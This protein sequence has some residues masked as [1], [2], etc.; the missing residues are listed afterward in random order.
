MSRQMSKNRYLWGIA[1]LVL[2]FGC[3]TAALLFHQSGLA[4]YPSL[5]AEAYKGR[6][7]VYSVNAE[8][9][10]NTAGSFGIIGLPT[11]IFF[12]GGQEVDRFSGNQD[13]NAIKERVEKVLA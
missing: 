7:A 2:I 11:C 6:L 9:A 13:L 8:D 10:Q 4:D 5:I 1:A 3:L 12:K